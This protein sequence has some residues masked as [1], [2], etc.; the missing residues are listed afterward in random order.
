MKCFDMQHNA[1][2]V[3]MYACYIGFLDTIKK[4]TYGLDFFQNLKKSRAL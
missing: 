2:H 4:A 3:K 1:L